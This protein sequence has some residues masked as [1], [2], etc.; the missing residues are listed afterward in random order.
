MTGFRS[1]R[2]FGDIEFGGGGYV[3]SIDNHRIAT[4]PNVFT[5]TDDHKI[6]RGYAV[7]WNK[8]IYQPHKEADYCVLLAGCFAASLVGNSVVRFLHQ[9]N[10]GRCVA[11]TRDYL[12]LHADKNGLAFELSI[13]SSKLGA[14]TKAL[15]T[16][17]DKT[18]ISVGFLRD[19][20]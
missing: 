11:T 12:T 5:P 16:A 4:A 15:V 6:L 19:R 8:P 20:L 7:R 2:G 13:P 1:R 3:D 17:H 18:A 14:E 9:H 10:E